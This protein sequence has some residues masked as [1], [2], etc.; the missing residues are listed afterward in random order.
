MKSTIL[1][2][3]LYLAA[4]A[5][6]LFVFGWALT[7]RREAERLAAQNASGARIIVVAPNDSVSQPRIRTR[8]S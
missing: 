5:L 7:A 8:T 4:L 1:A 6:G 3:K 2:L